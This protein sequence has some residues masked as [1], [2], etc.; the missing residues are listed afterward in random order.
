MDEV[1]EKEKELRE[2]KL[3]TNNFQVYQNNCSK[4]N[5][6]ESSLSWTKNKSH[7]SVLNYKKK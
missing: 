6:E 7:F 4:K 2:D 1:S 5:N 3:S